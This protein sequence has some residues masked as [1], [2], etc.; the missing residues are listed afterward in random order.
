MPD[1]KISAL[2]DGT[3]PAD[4]DLFPVARSTDNRRLS[5]LQMRTALAALFASAAQGT[6]SRE[7]T[8]ATVDQAEASIREHERAMQAQT[9][10]RRGRQQPPQQ[11][12]HL[13]LACGAPRDGRRSGV[14][15][16]RCLPIPRCS[17]QARRARRNPFPTLPHRPTTGGAGRGPR[18]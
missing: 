9:A 13:V 7:W 18:A 11:A 2:T 6:D 16:R 8:A 4:A 12:Q 14:R 1:T 5:W 3:T 17:D 15:R 10:P